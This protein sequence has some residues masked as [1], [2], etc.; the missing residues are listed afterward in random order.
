MRHLERRNVW[1][2]AAALPL[3]L[4]ACDEKNDG[5]DKDMENPDRPG[6]QEPPREVPMEPERS[7]PPPPPQGAQS[8]VL[9]DTESDK[10]EEK[11]REK[12]ALPTPFDGVS[13]MGTYQ[14]TF[15]DCTD[16]AR[17]TFTG[18]G[19]T[20]TSE[21]VDAN[22]AILDGRGRNAL[23]VRIQVVK[24]EA[25]KTEVTF[26][27]GNERDETSRNYVQELKSR[28]ETMIRQDVS[29]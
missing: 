14:A 5:M 27:A 11:D 12:S 1:S 9:A 4:A 3:L 26:T 23:P 6:Y 25:L 21:T 2:F 29:Q 19:V 15:A 7:T 8:A 20:K 17:R 22:S 10:E 28:F 24:V 16:A 13:A 18:L